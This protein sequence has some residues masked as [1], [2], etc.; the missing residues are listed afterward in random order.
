[1]LTACQLTVLER[2]PAAAP[3]ANVHYSSESWPA[4][5][6]STLTR[7]SASGAEAPSWPNPRRWPPCN[8]LQAARIWEKDVP[9]IHAVC[10]S[11]P[12]SR[13]ALLSPARHPSINITVLRIF[14]CTTNHFP[15]ISYYP[16]PFRL[17]SVF[18]CSLSSQHG[19]AGF[20]PSTA[21]LPSPAVFA[22]CSHCVRT[23]FALCSHGVP[24]WRHL[25]W[26]VLWPSF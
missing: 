23:V 16:A 14:C 24:G 9:R 4:R 26:P 20:R 13:S 5:V 17:T 22:L 15:H 12:H 21:Q 1:M 19:K 10:A 7:V 25:C 3:P 2:V 6:A 11:L 18:A 8:G